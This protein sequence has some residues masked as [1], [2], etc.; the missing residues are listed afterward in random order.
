MDQEVDIFLAHYGVKGMKWGVRN[1]KKRQ[2]LQA[3]AR[4]KKRGA[5]QLKN[6]NQRIKD[7]GGGIKGT[8]RVR[9]E[10]KKNGEL[11]KK[12]AAKGSARFARNLAV[13]V[14]VAVGAGYALSLLSKSGN[15]NVK[16]IPNLPDF[17]A[18]GDGW[19]LIATGVSN[20]NLEL[21]LKNLRGG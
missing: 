4:E 2:Q 14:S 19:E 9:N 1:E 12:Q 15:T 3:K 5:K 18:A 17:R 13:G 8:V 16:S 20:A 6:E 11:S 7:A 21:S 10:M